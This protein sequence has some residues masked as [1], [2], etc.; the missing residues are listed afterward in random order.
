LF[1]CFFQIK[2]NLDFLEKIGD[3][4]PVA[5]LYPQAL[6]FT[7]AMATPS[8]KLMVPVKSAFRAFGEMACPWPW[9]AK[10]YEHQFSCLYKGKNYG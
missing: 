1:L 4:W 3:T 7:V 5:E 10:P 6:P 8:F 9:T 2:E